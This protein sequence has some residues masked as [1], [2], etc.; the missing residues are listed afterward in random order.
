MSRESLT[1]AINAAT[2]AHYESIARL[3][4]DNPTVTLSDL[5]RQHNITQHEMGRAQ[6][7]FR[8]HRKTGKGSAAYRK[9]SIT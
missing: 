6:E 5:R 1:N 8:V 7:M 3:I 2:M 9:G 4:V